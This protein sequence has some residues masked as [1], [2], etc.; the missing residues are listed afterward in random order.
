MAL[1]NTSWLGKLTFSVWY[2]LTHRGVETDLLG[3]TL[4]NISWCGDWPCMLIDG[5]LWTFTTKSPS[6]LT[7]SLYKI[8]TTYVIYITASNPE[9]SCMSYFLSAKIYYIGKWHH[10]QTLYVH[11]LAM[12]L[13]KQVLN[14]NSILLFKNLFR[15]LI[16][17]TQ[18]S[19]HIILF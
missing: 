12:T 1:P 9:E 16:K 2:C 18:K 8:P 15:P 3:I 4:P 10:L 5:W 6:S 11:T 17:G 7:R 14:K 19:F 13:H